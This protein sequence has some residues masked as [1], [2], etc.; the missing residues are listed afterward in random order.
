[1][2]TS[3]I[4]TVGVYLSQGCQITAGGTGTVTVEGTGGA[5]TGTD[6]YGIYVRGTDAAITSGGGNITV[7]GIEG[8][9]ASGY[10]LVVDTNGAIT[11][12]DDGAVTLIGNSMSF[13]TTA[14]I[15]VG[16]GTV[17]IRQ[18]TPTVAID[19]GSTTDT[20]GGPLSLSEAELDRIT[21][22]ELHIGDSNSGAITVSSDINLSAVST[23]AGGGTVATLCLTTGSTVSAI[24]GVGGGG[25]V[26]SASKAEVVVSQGG[27]GGVVAKSCPLRRRGVDGGGEGGDDECLAC[28]S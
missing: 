14:V 4:E 10:A 1:M 3:S 28:G 8:G 26:E 21:A 23:G 17:T 27:G 25:I 18:L 7:T 11:H 16:A 20:V 22:G 2:S 5:T 24:E 13:D 9:G 15:D 6:N 12:T 19:L